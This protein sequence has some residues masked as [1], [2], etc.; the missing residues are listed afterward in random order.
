MQAIL[1]ACVHGRTL[2]ENPS[3][4]KKFST[5]GGMASWK[6]TPLATLLHAIRN[7]ATIQVEVQAED[8]IYMSLVI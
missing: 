6:F 3:K 2:Q 8:I 7:I 4:F 1:H 5:E